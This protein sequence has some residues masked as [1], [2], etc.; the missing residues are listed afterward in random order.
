MTSI[1]ESSNIVVGAQ[2]PSICKR[3][4]LE[5]IYEDIWKRFGKH[6]ALNTELRVTSTPIKISRRGTGIQL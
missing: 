2:I 4:Q 3:S 6:L 1:H 5:Q